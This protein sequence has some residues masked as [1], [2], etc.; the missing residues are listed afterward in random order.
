MVSKPA[1]G[2]LLRVSVAIKMIV[3]PGMEAT[4]KPMAKAMGKVTEGKLEPFSSN[5]KSI[6]A[7]LLTLAGIRS[8]RSRCSKR[9][10]PIERLERLELFQILYRV[11]RLALVT[12]LSF[13]LSVFC[14]QVE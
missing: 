6:Q 8:N 2:P 4:E 14:H 7:L 13:L 5:V 12:S 1:L 10:E 11:R 9:F 3:G